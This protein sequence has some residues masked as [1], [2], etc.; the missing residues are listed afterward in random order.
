MKHNLLLKQLILVTA[1]LV[2]TVQAYGY[3]DVEQSVSTDVQPAVAISKISSNESG[4]I[5]PV[6]GVSTGL[7]ASFK[8]ETNGTDEDYDFVVTSTLPTTDGEVSAYGQN[9]CLLFGNVTSLPTA[10]AVADA[11]VGGNN[12]R[13]VIAYPITMGITEPMSVD[14]ANSTQYGDCWVVKVNTGNEGT[15]TQTVGQTPVVNT[16]SIGQDESG[17]YK[18]TVTFTAFSK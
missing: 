17:T 18:A 15:L 12:N 14:F 3:A 7:S 10:A 1:V 9:G 2:G 11:K 4:T 13:N 8:L 6:N 16:Y 5:N